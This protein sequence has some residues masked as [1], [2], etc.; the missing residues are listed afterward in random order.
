MRY[1]RWHESL[2]TGDREVD[3]QHR[4][5]YDLVNDLNASALLGEGQQSESDALQGS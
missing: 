3:D 1:A 2:E 5:L 4:A